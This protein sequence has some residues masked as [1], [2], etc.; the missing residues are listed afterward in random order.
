M[1][2]WINEVWILKAG[3]CASD[4]SPAVA[5]AKTRCGQLPERIARADVETFMGALCDNDGSKAKP[6]TGMNQV[7]IAKSGIRPSN[8]AP[9]S[10]TGWK[11]S[12]HEHVNT[13]RCTPAASALR[14]QASGS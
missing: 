14:C 11:K 5:A 3:V 10:A 4:G 9:A 8:L 12:D 6:L 1:F 7:R 2:A 13:R